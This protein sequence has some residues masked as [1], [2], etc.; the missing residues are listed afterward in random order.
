MMLVTY[1]MVRPIKRTET[2]KKGKPGWVR[3]TTK[4]TSSHIRFV[5]IPTMVKAAVANGTAF[6]SS[7][8]SVWIVP[9]TMED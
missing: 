2:P 7:N 4:C 3:D 5:D 9:G 8:E 6:W 1:N